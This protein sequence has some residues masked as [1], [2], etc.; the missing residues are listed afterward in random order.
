MRPLSDDERN[1][2]LATIADLRDAK[3]QWRRTAA[4]FGEFTAEPSRLRI[5]SAARILRRYVLASRQHDIDVM[6][7]LRAETARALCLVAN[8]HKPS[9][10]WH[11]RAAERATRV[12]ARIRNA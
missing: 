2:V 5:R 1:D 10:L 12:I 9:Y 4:M 7:M 8:R 11:P 3:T 6:P